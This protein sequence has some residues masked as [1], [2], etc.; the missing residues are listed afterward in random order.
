MLYKVHQ[1]VSF[2]TLLVYMKS[3]KFGLQLHMEYKNDSY[4]VM[5]MQLNFCFINGA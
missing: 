3:F 1:Y 4:Q 2:G 5:S